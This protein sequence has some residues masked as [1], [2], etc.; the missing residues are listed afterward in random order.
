MKTSLLLRGALGLG[1]VFRFTWPS[2]PL[3]I[4]NVA[5]NAA[6]VSAAL[7]HRDLNTRLISAGLLTD[8]S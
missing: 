7:E 3:A 5:R 8:T 1:G 6:A 2:L 4:P